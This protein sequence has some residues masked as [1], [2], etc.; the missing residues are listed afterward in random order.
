MKER[1]A[2]LNR[3]GE[4]FGIRFGERSFLSN[5]R[6]ALE[7]SEFARDKGVYGLFHE[8]VFHAYFTDLLDIGNVDVLLDLATAEGLDTAELKRVLEEGVYA[9]RLEETMREAA[10]YGVNAVP[11]FIVNDEHKIVGALPLD[12]FRDRLSRISPK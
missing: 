11:T 4:P 3:A 2:G 6:P 7:A 8:R 5:S 12:S 10:R 1:Y 9:P